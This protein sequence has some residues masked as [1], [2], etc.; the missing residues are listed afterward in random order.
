MQKAPGSAFSI[1]P[2]HRFTQFALLIE[3]IHEIYIVFPMQ[4]EFQIESFP[5]GLDYEMHAN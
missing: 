2:L 1:S 5:N 4:E 3:Y